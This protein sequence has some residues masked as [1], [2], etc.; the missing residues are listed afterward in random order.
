MRADRSSDNAVADLLRRLEPHAAAALANVGD[1]SRSAPSI[2]AAM[3]PV[4]LA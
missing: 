1:E 4:G 3:G 2:L